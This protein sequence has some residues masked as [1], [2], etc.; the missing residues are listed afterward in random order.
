MKINKFIFVFVLLFISGVRESCGYDFKY[1]KSWLLMS[2]DEKESVETLPIIK[3][4][5]LYIVIPITCISVMTYINEE[6]SK[7]LIITTVVG[8]SMS[9]LLNYIS[10]T[11][12]DPL[13]STD[14]N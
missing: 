6:L 7:K 4:G 5:F 2:K 13:Q 11:L 9:K 14:E 3:D 1:M 10:R 12:E 8:Y